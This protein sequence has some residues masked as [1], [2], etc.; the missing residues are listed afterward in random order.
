MDEIT[1]DL[2]I[3]QHL[4]FKIYSQRNRSTLHVSLT[5]VRVIVSHHLLRD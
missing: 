5:K 4:L 3:S 2:T 1:E